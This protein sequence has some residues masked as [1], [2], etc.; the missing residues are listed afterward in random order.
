[1]KNPVKSRVLVFIDWYSP[2]YKAGG[3]VRSM[4]NMTE[5]LAGE[6]DFFIVSRDSEYGESTPYDS[7]NSN[8]WN[9]LSSGVKVWYSSAGTPSLKLWKQL[10]T[11][12]NPDV[13][14]INGIYSPKF[15]LLPVIAA[16]RMKCKTIIVAPRGMLAT[17]AINVKQCK[18]NLFLRTVTSLNL[19][20]NVLWHATNQKEA[21]EVSVRLFVDKSNIYVVPNLPRIA[22]KNYSISFKN[23]W[24]LRLVSLSRVAPE[25]NTQYA[26]ECLSLIG[27]RYNIELD[28]Y[29][30]I[31]NQDYW[32]LCEKEIYKLPNHIQVNYRGVADSEFIPEIIAKYNALLLPSRGE[33]FGH[34]ILES[35]MTGRPVL[36]SDQTPWKNLTEI[37][38][39]WDL[40]LSDP[41]GFSTTLESLASMN[42]EE[43]DEW[44]KGAWALGQSVANDETVVEEYKGMLKGEGLG[45]R[46]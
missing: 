35:F 11:E 14:Y 10:I 39:G 29:G 34:V 27:D 40:P 1:M 25:K 43:Y 44:C 31:Y 6:F 32:Q 3:P 30:Q 38:A 24:Q 20:K 8:A 23:K 4:I 7:V 46:E 22:L 9:E 37:K 28:L 2:G 41:S 21:D 45:G 16:R 15:S 18:K 17:S 13:V 36:I 5:H 33:N 42:Q 26:I 12:I 19:Y